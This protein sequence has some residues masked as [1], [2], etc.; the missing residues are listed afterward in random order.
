[1]KQS[2]S[3]QQHTHQQVAATTK[4]MKQNN[5]WQKHIQ[6]KAAIVPTSNTAHCLGSTIWQSPHNQVLNQ[7]GK[8]L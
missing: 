7:C 4:Y 1:M 6:N 8:A 3:K 2:N 5:R